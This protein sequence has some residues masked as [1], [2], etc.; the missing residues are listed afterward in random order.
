MSQERVALIT[1]L[2][3]DIVFATGASS[4]QIES[5]PTVVVGHNTSKEEHG[6]RC[7]IC[8]EDIEAGAMLR[9]LT[10]KHYF[11][12]ACLDKWLSH[13]S[14]CPICQQKMI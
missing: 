1:V 11:H 10:C 4:E 3:F 8:L 13:K 5:I 7:P 2:A 9:K 6:C 12:K 14:V